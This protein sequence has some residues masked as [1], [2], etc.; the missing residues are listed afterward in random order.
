MKISPLES[1]HPDGPKA[2]NEIANGMLPDQDHQFALK[3]IVGRISPGTF[4]I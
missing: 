3:S 4:L 2:L 1:D